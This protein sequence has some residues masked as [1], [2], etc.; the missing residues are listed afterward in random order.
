MKRIA[1]ATLV[2]AFILGGDIPLEAID[3]GGTRIQNNKGTSLSGLPIRT[4]MNINQISSWYDNDGTEEYNSST[5]NSGLV[6]PQGTAGAIFAAGLMWSGEFLDGQTPTVRTN[7][8]A[9][10]TGL[11]PGAILGVRT[12]VIEDP[13]ADDVRIWRVRR[14]YNSAD[15]ARDAAE[16]NSVGLSSVSEAQITAVRDQYEKDWLE[17]PAAKGAPFYDADSDGVYTPMIVDGVPVLFPTADEPGIADADQVIWYTANDIGNRSPWGA[18]PPGGLEMQLTIWGYARADALGNV[19]FKKYRLIY[20][21]TGSTPADAAV[22]N[23]YLSQWSDPDLGNAADDYAGCDITLSLGFCYNANPTDSNFDDFGIRP[24]AVGYDFL[25]GPL[26]PGVAG[27]DRNN[28]GIDDATDTGIFDLKVTSPG[29]INLPMTSFIYFAAG[30]TYS[31]PL[32]TYPAA[33][34]WNCMLQGLPPTPQPPPCPEPPL[35]PYTNQ[36]AGKY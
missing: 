3:S 20:K 17:W 35:D 28:N 1:F 27:E 7:G 22:E 2:V 5:G 33:L 14:N 8:H 36:P 23:M 15:L 24:P 12:G 18:T 11:V 4:K 16:I 26:V 29:F 13:A 25:Q 19:L 9:Y 10:N 31:D 21:G 34:Q 32:F 30:G 6:Y